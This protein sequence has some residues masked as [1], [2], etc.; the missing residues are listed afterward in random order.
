MRFA[1]TLLAV[2]LLV[3]GCSRAET[4]RFE[5]SGQVVAIDADRLEVTIKHG[6]IPGYMAAMTMP[7]KVKDASAL[8]PLAA[9]DL[10]SATL[11]VEEDTAYLEN[12]RKTGVAEA[13]AAGS[14]P[15]ASSGFELL[16]VGEEIPDVAFVDQQGRA[17][18]L[19]DTRGKAVAM[20]FIYTRCPVPTFCPQMDK[21]FGLIQRRVK[22]SS[23][24]RDHVQLVS[25]S[26]DPEHDTP[27]VL[28]QH[29]KKLGADPATWS[30]A[31]GDRDEIDR[32]A[33]RFGVN[34][35]R[36]DQS[37][38]IAH[39]LRTVVVDPRGEIVQI[40]KGFDW[41]P[42]QVVADLE[43]AAASGD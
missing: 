9:R 27:A 38:D 8:Q 13:P 42:E 6:E 33:A 23:K 16:A 43:S 36:S 18:R 7:F 14:P 5:L 21:Q 4:R 31:T 3:G 28:A 22:G 34:V 30:F 12:L 24:L 39:M 37:G 32:F 25:I 17:R 10:V 1:V 41:K 40:Y 11:V 19:S 2:A 20:T 35:T 26:F 29:A 15:S